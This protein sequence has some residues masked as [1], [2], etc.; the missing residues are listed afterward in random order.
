MQLRTSGLT[1]QIVG[2]DV[3]V[4]DLE[5]STYLKLDG[6]G[7]TLWEAL[8]ESCTEDELITLLVDRYAIDASEATQDVAAFLDELRSRRLLDES[9]STA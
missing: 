2:A 1:W 4:L 6:S 3:I 9:S 5:G 7:R 8:S